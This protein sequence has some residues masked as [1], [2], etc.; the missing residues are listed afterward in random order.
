MVEEVIKLTLL[1]ELE[2]IQASLHPTPYV[3]QILSP[4]EQNKIADDH[5][6]L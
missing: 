3:Q 1:V 4:R 5:Q 6:G 2:E